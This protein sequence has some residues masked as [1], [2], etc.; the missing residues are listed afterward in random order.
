MMGLAVI[1]VV[2]HVPRS[3]T[4]AH[5]IKSDKPVQH[6]F[7]MHC[8]RTLWKSPSSSSANPSSGQGRKNQQINLARSAVDATTMPPRRVLGAARCNHCITKLSLPRN[9]RNMLR[10][11][12]MDLPL[13]AWLRKLDAA[14]RVAQSNPT[15]ISCE[16]RS[17]KLFILSVARA[18]PLQYPHLHEEH[19]VVNC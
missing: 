10:V 19:M 18:T 17:Y 7:S 3:H 9:T 14:C 2:S 16:S 4:Y 6:T 8:M 1:G 15:N 11:K 13:H 12:D 5:H